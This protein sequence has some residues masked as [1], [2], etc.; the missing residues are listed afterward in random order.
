MLLCIDDLPC[1]RIN[2]FARTVS[3]LMERHMYTGREQDAVKPVHL[4]GFQTGKIRIRKRSVRI[5]RNGTGFFPRRICK[6]SAV[7]NE[8]NTVEIRAAAQT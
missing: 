2:I 3:D 7:I 1:N 5:L 8:N 6:P 4:I